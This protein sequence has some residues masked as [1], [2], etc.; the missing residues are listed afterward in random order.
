M[1]RVRHPGNG[2]LGP[3]KPWKAWHGSKPSETCGHTP[4]P[5]TLEFI[6]N[7][8]PEV[9]ILIQARKDRKLHALSSKHEVPEPGLL[10]L[11]G[12]G[13]WSYT[14]LQQSLLSTQ[15]PRHCSGIFLGKRGEGRDV[16]QVWV[17]P[18]NNLYFTSGS[19]S[20]P[21]AYLMSKLH[22]QPLTGHSFPPG[23]A[24]WTLASKPP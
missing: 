18:R 15:E 4:G 1:T 12:S 24:M 11:P 10:C 17:F 19:H 5:T 16:A 13:Y 23:R 7:P 22:F 14:S 8:C 20:Y 3:S 21:L 2:A 9:Y 6:R